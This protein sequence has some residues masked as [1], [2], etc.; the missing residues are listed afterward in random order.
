MN[1]PIEFTQRKIKKNYRSVTG[2]FPSIKNNKSIA[3]NSILEKE[4]FLTLEFDDEVI[5]YQEQPQIEIFL[6]VKTK[7][8]V[9]IAIS[10]EHQLPK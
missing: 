5:L 9:L 8:I 2:H 10:I 6:M 1:A 7:F 4:L 3:F